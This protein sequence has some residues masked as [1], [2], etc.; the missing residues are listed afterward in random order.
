MLVTLDGSRAKSGD[1]VARSLVAMLHVT[2]AFTSF[3]LYRL[4]QIILIYLTSWR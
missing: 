2:Q 1:Q 4:S 3:S